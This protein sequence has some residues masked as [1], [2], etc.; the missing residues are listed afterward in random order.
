MF[1]GQNII[2]CNEYTQHNDPIPGNNTCTHVQVLI[3]P[4]AKI[5]YK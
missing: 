5:K 3:E 4:F 1:A 2:I